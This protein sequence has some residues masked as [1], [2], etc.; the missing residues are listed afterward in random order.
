[1]CLRSRTENINFVLDL[2][3]RRRY[4]AY[5]LLRFFIN[6][7]VLTPFSRTYFENNKSTDKNQNYFIVTSFQFDAWSWMNECM[8]GIRFCEHF[9]GCSAIAATVD[10]TAAA[11]AAA[12]VTFLRNCLAKSYAMLSFHTNQ[13]KCLLLWTNWM[14]RYT[15]S[16]VDRNTHG[17]Y[18]KNVNR[19]RL[20]FFCMH[21]HFD[22]FYNLL[23][24]VHIRTYT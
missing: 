22:S 21:F 15:Y 3:S 13:L 17:I 9:V 23:F 7:F 2:A 11:A 4:A 18:G 8:N 14:P 6:T 10:R 12:A 5:E 16:S 19:M 24:F 20:D 1:M